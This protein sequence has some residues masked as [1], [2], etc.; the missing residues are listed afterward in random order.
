MKKQMEELRVL[1]I[2][3]PYVDLILSGSKRVENRSWQARLAPGSTIWIHSS[4]LED[5]PSLASLSEEFSEEYAKLIYKL[6]DAP[7][8]RLIGC[9]VG[10]VTLAGIIDVDS[11]EILSTVPVGADVLPSYEAGLMYPSLRAGFLA[12]WRH[13]HEFVA[14]ITNK[15]FD[16]HCCGPLCWLLANPRALVKPIPIGGKLNLWKLR[17]P[18][19]RLVFR[20]HRQKKRRKR[21]RGHAHRG[22]GD[23]E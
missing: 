7:G 20:E 18:S 21:S 19:D 4:R 13:V 22:D 1:S 16:T 11:L 10:C 3:Q 5:R 23:D 2:R 8:D 17:V 14:S 6:W 12:K 9:I 15:E